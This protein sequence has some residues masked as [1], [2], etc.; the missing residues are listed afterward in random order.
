MDCHLQA[1]LKGWLYSV[2][3]VAIHRQVLP[4]FTNSMLTWT[5][6][7]TFDQFPESVS[8]L[9]AWLRKLQKNCKADSNLSLPVSMSA[10]W[11]HIT[12]CF[13]WRVFSTIIL[14]VIL[15]NL[16]PDTGV[17]PFC[18]SISANGLW[19][20]FAM[21]FMWLCKSMPAGL[22]LAVTVQFRGTPLSV[23]QLVS[24]TD[25]IHE[26]DPQTKGLDINWDCDSGLGILSYKYSDVS[27][28][29]IPRHI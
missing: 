11:V 12:A 1:R 17:P 2:K 29:G 10:Y 13:P 26:D 27:Y 14:T 8:G 4:W 19:G 18:N 28:Q 24:A 16:H 22:R 9:P 7:G 20:S 15:L 6:R 25:S 21:T 3:R 23:T 5:C